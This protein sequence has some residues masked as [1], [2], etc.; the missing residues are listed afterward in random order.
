MKKGSKT[1]FLASS[2]VAISLIAV[3]LLLPTNAVL[4]SSI[5]LGDF[6]SYCDASRFL[7]VTIHLIHPS[8][9][10]T[11]ISLALFLLMAKR[12]SNSGKLFPAGI[13]AGVSLVMTGGYFHG[14][15]KSLK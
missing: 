11:G 3:F 1:S 9:H 6:F 12:Y 14:I 15:Q 5:G 2:I 10:C 4:A 8:S 7:S 13:V